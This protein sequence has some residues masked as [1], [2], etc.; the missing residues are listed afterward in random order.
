M[1]AGGMAIR[2]LLTRCPKAVGV[3]AAGRMGCP[4]SAAAMFGAVGQVAA[5]HGIEPEGL[6]ETMNKTVA[7]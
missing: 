3:F 1:I 7:R 2:D 6:L 4:G 5:A